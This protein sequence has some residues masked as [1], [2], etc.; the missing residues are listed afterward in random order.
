EEKLDCRGLAC[1]S[2][3]LKTREVLERGNVARVS[4]LVDNSAA[5]ENVSRF[6]SRMGYAVSI[7]ESEGALEVMGAREESEAP[8]PI[9]A[10]H[11]SSDQGSR[12]TVLVGTEAMGKGDDVLGRKL[13]INFI[14]TLKEMGP[15][16]WRLILLNG[17]VKLAVEGS[18]CL[19]TLQALEK[20][21]IHILVCGT[22]LNHFELIEK[23]QVGETT[24]M[25]DIVTALQLADK[26]ITVM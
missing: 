6:L 4:I 18:E 16:L 22:C 3:V 13:I 21:G 26:V 24:N 1:P 12:I 25:L 10:E 19:E 2:P 8:C 11:K 5:Q 17:G 23:K 20:D 7:S 15:E 14:G 9:M